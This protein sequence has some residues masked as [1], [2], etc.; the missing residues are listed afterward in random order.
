MRSLY[1]LL[2]SGFSM[3]ALAA[4]LAPAPPPPP[5]PAEAAPREVPPAQPAPARSEAMPAAAQ[6]AGAA[7]EEPEVIITKQTEQ[8]I[9]E[10]RI[11]GRL[12]M[13]KII[14]KAGAP[15]YLVDDKGDGK[16]SRMESLDSGL[17]VPRWI[18]HRF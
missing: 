2:L 3:A 9:E 1:L 10:Y 18:I 14:P 8:T 17:R 13:I 6:G 7:G 15:Y 16:F 11:G 12:Y 5:A 4:E